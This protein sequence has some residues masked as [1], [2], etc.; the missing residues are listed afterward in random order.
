MPLAK[1]F[2]Y[3]DKVRSLTQGRASWTMEPQRYAPVPEDVLRGFLNPDE[4]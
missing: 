1:M 3:S 4:F 2:D